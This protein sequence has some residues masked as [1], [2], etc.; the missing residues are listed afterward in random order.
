ML[1]FS[2]STRLEDFKILEL[3]N[4]RFTLKYMTYIAYFIALASVFALIYYGGYYYA[5][6]YMKSDNLITIDDALKNNPS[7]SS[8]TTVNEADEQIVSAKATYTEECY[9]T[10]T[11]ELT[12]Q[13]LKMPVEYIGLT[14]DDVIDYLTTYKNNVSDETLI[15]IQLVSFSKDSIVVRKTVCNPIAIYNYYV[16]SEKNIIKIYNAN[17]DV[18]YIDTGIDI[19]NLEEEYIEELNNGFYIETIH[20]L[21]N[22]LEGVTS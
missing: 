8:V 11:D 20:E 19:S 21:Y 14:R 1:C 12:T 15:N 18:L 9:N 17:R 13:E 5:I 3:K 4:M 2:K 6:N 10:D 16:I 22:Y 7:I